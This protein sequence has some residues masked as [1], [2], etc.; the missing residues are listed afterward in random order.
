MNAEV[1]ALWVMPWSLTSRAKIDSV[2]ENA[3]LSGYNELLLEVRYRSDA[4]YTPNNR[5]S[6]YYNPEPRSYILAD[7]GFDPLAYAIKRGHEANLQVQAWV[8]VFNA[9]PLDRE[10][11]QKNYIFKNHPD[12]ITYDNTGQRMRNS[13]QFGY[14]ID[15]AIPE[16][17]EHLFEVFCDI[18][19]GY[20]ELDGLHLDYIRYPNVSLGFHPTSLE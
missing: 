2:I 13:D 5:S 17:R 7:N 18:V 15:P 10:L 4:L 20:P 6:R 8:V 9:T 3:V 11:I 19:D 1:R 16:V 12:W 14:Y